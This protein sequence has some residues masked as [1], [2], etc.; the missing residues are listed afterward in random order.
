M[1]SWLF[2]N[3]KTEDPYLSSSSINY[4]TA[5]SSNPFSSH[6]MKPN[7]T[8][9][10]PENLNFKRSSA[11]S[12]VEVV[13][14]D[15][16]FHETGNPL[17]MRLAPAF[18]SSSAQGGPENSTV[19]IIA[20]WERL[21]ISNKLGPIQRSGK[22]RLGDRLVRINE[23]DITHMSFRNVMDLLKDLLSLHN[24]NRKEADGSNDD[25]EKESSVKLKTLGFVPLT[26]NQQQ[27][28]KNEQHSSR[29]IEGIGSYFSGDN[30]MNSII[31]LR[32]ENINFCFSSTIRSWR[33]NNPNDSSTDETHDNESI[34]MEQDYNHRV[35]QPLS[36]SSSS[37]NYIEYEIECQLISRCKKNSLSRVGNRNSSKMW[38]VW[39]VS[40]TFNIQSLLFDAS[41]YMQ[42]FYLNN[43][44]LS[45]L[46]FSNILLI[47][48]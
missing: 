39:R 12:N 40:M 46:C 3:P 20:A 18:L 36:S 19:V 35:E 21:P 22:V 6:N 38:K 5:T 8:I 45:F 29:N 33:M 14:V 37:S 42:I 48:K 26:L 44:M 9:S 4:N 16:S 32:D 7:F 25:G 34:P 23:L 41:Y 17:G 27:I 31:A 47:Q 13:T 2:E 1:K 30:Y 15:L 10:D 43:D 11:G 24:K 28:H